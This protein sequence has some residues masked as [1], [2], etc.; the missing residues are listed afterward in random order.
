MSDRANPRNAPF[1]QR[2]LGTRT[3]WQVLQ[4]DFD[5]SIAVVNGTSI[6]PRFS[7]DLV[8]ALIRSIEI[9]KAEATPI[10]TPRS[11]AI[12]SSFAKAR[13]ISAAVGTAS[14]E[15]SALA[16]GT[17]WAIASEGATLRGTVP[18]SK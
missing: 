3:V 15:T 6:T 12:P 10:A 7:S 11:L 18:S 8:H 2:L 9:G 1:P 4:L 16:K 17:V 14:T 13:S 5:F